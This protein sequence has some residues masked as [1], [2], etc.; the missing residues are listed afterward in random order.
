M[1]AFD[2]GGGKNHVTKHRKLSTVFVSLNVKI[3]ARCVKNLMTSR[4]R[5]TQRS[6]GLW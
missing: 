6:E 2:V 5:P 1:E 3:T 4:K